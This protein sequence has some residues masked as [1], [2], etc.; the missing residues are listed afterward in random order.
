L[1]AARPRVVTHRRQPNFSYEPI[2]YAA[3]TRVH[4]VH[5]LRLLCLA[6]RPTQ[7]LTQTTHRL[8]NLYVDLPHA[9]LPRL[10]GLP[11]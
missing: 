6:Y 3:D 8:L 2:H 4:S 9:S 5:R 10:T 7:T 11:L 1:T